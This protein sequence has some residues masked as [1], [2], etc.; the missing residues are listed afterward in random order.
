M[1]RRILH[2]LIAL[3]S[4]VLFVDY[5]FLVLGQPLSP[6]LR[7]ALGFMV[8]SVLLLP[9]LVYLWILHNLRVARRWRARR[10]ERQDPHE[11]FHE[12]FLGRSLAGT[13]LHTLQGARELVIELQGEHKRYRAADSD[14]ADGRP[15][16]GA[17]EAT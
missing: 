14:A 15:G 2:I 1:I 3:A 9:I 6:G 12:D 17:E 16:P 7:V 4:W 8:V 10:G 11:D 13:D 5:W